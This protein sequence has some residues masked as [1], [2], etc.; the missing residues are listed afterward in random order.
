[1]IDVVGKQVTKKIPVGTGPW[2]IAVVRRS[3]TR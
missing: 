2:G 1:V 3:S